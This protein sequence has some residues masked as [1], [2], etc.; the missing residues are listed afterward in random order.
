MRM[1]F[2]RGGSLALAMIAA[3]AF[4]V[5][6]A[7][8]RV[9]GGRNSGSR[10]DRTFQAPSSTNVAPN[11]QN[12]NRSVT[13]PN[14]VQRQAAP[15]AGAASTGSRFGGFAGG[16]FAGL[17]GAGLI[18]MLMGGGFLSGLSGLGSILGLLLQVALI[19]G[20]IY[21]AVQFF[22]RRSQAQQ[23]AYA[24]PMA[25]SPLED[26]QR[27]GLGGL[28]AGGFGAP[29]SDA[30]TIEQRDYEQFERIL[31]EVQV[32]SSREDV[33]TIRRVTTPEMA[34]YIEEDISENARKGL[35]NEVSDVKFEDGD[36]SEA[37]REG[38]TEY[39]TVG[40]RFSLVDVTKE[41]ATGRIVE[42]STSP[43]QIT[44]VWTFR[45][46]RGDDSWKLS[47]IQQA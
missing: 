3:L 1:L 4:T 8:A 20:L 44:E 32:A 36:L 40:M 13:Q 15:T 24:G 41:R 7:D 14:Q 10:G 43:V 31:G 23:P 33:G 37:W 45:R 17:L 39:A 11:S 30:V 34:S 46:D 22:R 6:V 12:I 9:G 5:S 25:R 21:F 16:L 2:S 42:G 26:S 35:I 18:G 19:G 29:Q 38:D 27:R 28:G 47:A